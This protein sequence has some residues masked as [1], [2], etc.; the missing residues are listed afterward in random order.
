MRVT[1]DHIHD[2][3]H[4][5]RSFF[6]KPDGPFAYIAGQYTELTVPHD[7]PDERGTKHWFT[8][9]SSPTQQLLS[10][11]TKLATEHASTFKQALWKLPIGTKLHMADSMG[12]F[13]LPKDK[14]IPLVFVAGG[15]GCTPFHSMI[16]WLTDTNEQRDIQLIYSVNRPEEVAFKSLFESYAKKFQL[17]LKEPSPEWDGPT[18][19]LSADK[20][21]ELVGDPTGKMIFLSGPEQ[22]V[23]GF[24]KDL[25][26]R[27]VERHLLV[28]DDF[29]GYTTI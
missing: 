27:G 8:I 20:I 11:T 10:I 12:D 13:V 24:E 7:S 3:A 16:Q 5:I 9:S 26:D 1:L 17:L 22:M 25:L 15:I 2:E 28:V 6:F 14:T 18:G 23:K 4:N 29:P 19:S 21:L